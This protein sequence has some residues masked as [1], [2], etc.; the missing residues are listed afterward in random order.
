M[1]DPGEKQR[2]KQEEANQKAAADREKAEEMRPKVEANLDRLKKVRIKAHLA[3]A[4]G[5]LPVHKTK[6]ILA[7]LDEEEGE[8][9]E[10]LDEINRGI[11]PRRNYPQDG[12]VQM[13]NLLRREGFMVE[14]NPTIDTLVDLVLWYSG[15]DDEEVIL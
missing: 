11:I 8:L 6:E 5:K 13:E 3:M 10:R 12:V 4:L 15:D 14:N 1:L 2:K 7:E 9:N